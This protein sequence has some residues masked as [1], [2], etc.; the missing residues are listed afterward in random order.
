MK[1]VSFIDL[2]GTLVR[3]QTQLAFLPRLFRSGLVSRPQVLVMVGHYGMFLAGFTKNAEA[4][5]TRS[6]AAFAGAKAAKLEHNARHHVH[7]HTIHQLRT[8]ARKLVQTEL[9]SGARCVLITAAA[10]MLARPMA[11]ALGFHDV[12]ATEFESVDGTL[13]GKIAT[14]SPYGPGKRALVER[15]CQ[16]H[17]LDPAHARAFADHESD[18]SLL[19]FVGHPHVV[20]P[21]R[22]LARIGRERGWPVLDLDASG[23]TPSSSR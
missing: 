1:T 20:N 12:I 3:G 4:L 14:P 9:E 18:V 17:R 7:T 10:G 8:G 15:Y 13:T 16:E 11:V 19:E 22:K 21:T 5:R 2:D 6:Y 23:P